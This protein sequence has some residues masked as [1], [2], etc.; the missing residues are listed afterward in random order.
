MFGFQNKHYG[1]RNPDQKS[2]LWMKGPFE[3]R[4]TTCLVFG[5]FLVIQH[6]DFESPLCYMV[7]SG[8]AHYQFSQIFCEICSWLMFFEKMLMLWVPFFFIANLPCSRAW[9]STN[10]QDDQH[11]QE[12]FHPDLYHFLLWLDYWGFKKNHKIFFLATFITFT[13]LLG[14]G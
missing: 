8:T 11:Q 4:T 7:L 9:P 14:L 1:I 10:D 13:L 3:N 12:P 2:W 5:M 6:S